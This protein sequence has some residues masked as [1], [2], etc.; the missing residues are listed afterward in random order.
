[1]TSRT[2]MNRRDVLI[3]GAV[4]AASA[5][6]PG[7][8]RAQAAF[9]PQP[10]KWRNLQTVTRRVIAKPAGLTQAWMP[11]PAFS[12]AEWFRPAGSTWTTNAPSAGIKRDAKYGARC[13]MWCG[14][15]ASRHQWWKSPANSPRD[16]AIDLTQS[17]ARRP[18]E[19]ERKL[20]T[21]AP[22]SFRGQHRQKPSQDR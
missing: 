16:R 10:G 4:F 18:H 6:L 14:P 15:M 12:D 22:P 9:A 11:L 13:C 17:A 1:M 3:A 21:K 20:H 2:S 19:A 8:A 5:A 7:K